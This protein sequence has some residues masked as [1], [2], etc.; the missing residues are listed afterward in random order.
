[1]AEAEKQYEPVKDRY[2]NRLFEHFDGIAF[3]FGCLFTLL[4]LLGGQMIVIS[5]LVEK[6]ILSSGLEALAYPYALMVLVLI[7]LI[8]REFLQ[9]TLYATVANTGK[10]RAYL[11]AGALVAVGLAVALHSGANTAGF[12][13]EQASSYY[14]IA[15]AM[16]FV[17]GLEVA[18]H[19]GVT[20]S[21]MER[22]TRSLG[23]TS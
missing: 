20:T 11:L 23:V 22:L 16:S 14:R 9:W 21:D 4:A 3:R 12:T 8:L 2:R 5:S 13:A 15:Y 1:M 10:H 19:G 18:L 7:W 17:L 6:G